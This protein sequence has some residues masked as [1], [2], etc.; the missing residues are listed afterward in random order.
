MLLV[1]GPFVDSIEA[2]AALSAGFAAPSRS[3]QDPGR[4]SASVREGRGE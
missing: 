3:F 2:L 1:S 4:E